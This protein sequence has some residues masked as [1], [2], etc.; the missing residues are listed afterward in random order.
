MRINRREFL[1][2]LGGASMALFSAGT[3][4]VVYQVAQPRTDFRDRPDSF[5]FEPTRL[6]PRSDTP[7][8]FFPEAQAWLI[9]DKS[10]LLALSAKCTVS[11]Q[12]LVKWVDIN[13]R[14][15]CPCSGSKFQLDGTYISGPAPRNLD[16]FILHVETSNGII[17]TGRRLPGVD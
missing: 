5:G 7:F 6:H 15:E 2:Y 14:F 11:R 1:F 12:C 4:A 8:F 10:G 17:H 3:C 13:R 16:R 9:P